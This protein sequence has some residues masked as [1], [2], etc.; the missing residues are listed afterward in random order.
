MNVKGLPVVNRLLRSRAYITDSPAPR[1][2]RHLFI[3]G[4]PLHLV[5]K[6]CPAR[7]AAQTPLYAVAPAATVVPNFPQFRP[8][9]RV[10][11]LS[12]AKC[13]R[14]RPTPVVNQTYSNVAPIR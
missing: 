9:H 5:R 13:L 3:R 8:F 4:D 12:F 14:I 11:G 10:S 2:L 6:P 7:S 1:L